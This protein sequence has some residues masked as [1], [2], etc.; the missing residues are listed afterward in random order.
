TANMDLETGPDG[1][2]WYIEGGGYSK[3]TLKRIVGPGTQPVPT[4]PTAPATS[5]PGAVPTVMVPGT[6]SRAF[7]ETGK[8][9]RGL[10][11][12]YWEKN[13]GLP[14]QG[15]PISDVLGEVSDLNGK[16]YTVQYFERAVFEYH[17]ENQAPFNVLLS[18]LGT[19]QYKKKYPN[20]APN[21]KPNNEAGSVLFPQTNKRVGGKFLQ[22]WQQNG[23]VAQ[24]GYPISEEFQEKSDLNG[25]TYTVQYF[26]RA[27]FEL[28]PEN[29]GTPYEVLLS[30]L[31]T[32]RLREKPA[33][34]ISAVIPM[35]SKPRVIAAGEGSLW[36]AREDGGVSRIDMN[37][38][39]I[40]G[41]PVPL[42]FIAPHDAAFGSGSIWITGETKD[43]G[44]GGELRLARLDPRAGKVVAN[45]R[46]PFAT[47]YNSIAA[48]DDAAWVTDPGEE[49]STVSRIDPR[50]NLFKGQ[51]LK[52]GAEP[53]ALALG[54][55]SL[56]TGNHDDGTVYRID[57]ASERVLAR[58]DMGFEVHNIAFGDGLLW[59]VDY[60]GARVSAIDPQ[61][62]N[63]RFKS[64]KLGFTPEPIAAGDGNVWVAATQFGGQGSQ[65]DGRVAHFDSR[66]GK[67][68][69]ILNVGGSPLDVAIGNGSAWVA[70]MSPNAIVRVQP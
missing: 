43:E 61:T 41:T 26:E 19:F 68:L 9:V 3:G 62:N 37:T 66:T 8:T 60:H 39:K 2:L 4:P 25:Q 32:F 59:V 51:P 13:G 64:A 58:I 57:P 67:L 20:G 18:Q 22:Y 65:G 33:G 40:A 29:A 56:W 47:N 63:V 10:F 16:P 48:Q 24:Q 50:T 21:Q 36:V 7:P 11:L 70:T 42:G 38:G 23:G 52:V 6:N 31:G 44:T 1:A 12:D 45:V 5:T 17:P 30:Q 49:T 14:Q 34:R 53:L 27:V 69:G 54:A 55:G 35:G 46:L 28:H 15:F